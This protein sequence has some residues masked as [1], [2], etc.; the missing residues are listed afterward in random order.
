MAFCVKVPP[1]SLAACTCEGLLVIV[2][3]ETEV[4]YE[5]ARDLAIRYSGGAASIDEEAAEAL[6]AQAAKRVAVRFEAKRTASWDH[7]KLG[8]PH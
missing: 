3:F 5:L 7:R 2:A 6:R 8:S 1:E 4:V